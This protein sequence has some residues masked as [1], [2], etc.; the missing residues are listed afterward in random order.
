MRIC[1]YFE[2]HFAEVIGVILKLMV[3]VTIFVEINAF[4]HDI[5]VLLG[6]WVKGV[7][8]QNLIFI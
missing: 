6:D 7:T 3:S 8:F 4:S 1:L 2:M 5:L